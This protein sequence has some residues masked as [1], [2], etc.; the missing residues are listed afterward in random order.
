MYAGY[1]AVARTASTQ[2]TTRAREK[3]GDRYRGIISVWFFVS[4]VSLPPAW[5]SLLCD[6]PW[7]KYQTLSSTF[8]KKGCS[9]MTSLLSLSFG[10]FLISCSM[11]ETAVLDRLSGYSMLEFYTWINSCLRLGSSSL[12]LCGLCGRREPSLPTAHKSALPDTISQPYSRT[13]LPIR[14]MVERSRKCRSKSSFD[15][16]RQSTS[17]NHT[18]CRYPK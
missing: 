12:S 2:T 7:D 15:H 16:R 10:S 1:S 13:R 14:S 11:N 4:F 17:R 18:V 8:F 5:G 6:C 9:N 3:K